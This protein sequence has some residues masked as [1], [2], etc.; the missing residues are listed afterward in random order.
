MASLV[1]AGLSAKDLFRPIVMGALNH[2]HPS[3]GLHLLY[4]GIFVWTVVQEQ[5]PIWTTSIVS[6]RLAI[7]FLRLTNRRI[8]A[9]VTRKLSAFLIKSHQTAMTAKTALILDF[10]TTQHCD[11]HLGLPYG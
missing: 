2:L 3:L 9:L 8:G 10:G 7:Q 11:I 1:K 4:G 5:V 6:L